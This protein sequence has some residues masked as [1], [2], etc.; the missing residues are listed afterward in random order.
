MF[1]LISCVAI[2]ATVAS[3]SAYS[4]RCGSDLVYEGDSEYTVM[5]KCGESNDTNTDAWG[6]KKTLYYDDGNGATEEVKIL[7]GRV[8]DVELKRNL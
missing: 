5:Q 8:T 2:F 4:L 3:S 6:D 7:N 1:K